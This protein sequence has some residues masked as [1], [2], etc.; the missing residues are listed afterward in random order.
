MSTFHFI[1]GPYLLL[2]IAAAVLHILLAVFSPDP[3]GYVWDF[4]SDA[5]IWV[6]QNKELPMVDSCWVCYHPPLLPVIGAAIFSLV[7]FFTDSIDIKLFVVTCLLNLVSLIFCIYA[8]AIYLKFRKH[9]KLDLVLW[10]FLL[11]VPVRFIASFSI[12]ADVLVSTFIVI[13]LYYFVLFT[14]EN[15]QRTL[16]LSAVFIGLA[17]LT[18][19]TGVVIAA[20]YGGILLFRFLKNIG[21]ENFLNGLKFFLITFVIGGF[22]YVNNIIN[23]GT[24]IKGNRAWDNPGYYMYSYKEF[25]IPK[26]IQTFEDDRP[27]KLKHYPQYNSEV[28]NSLYGQIWTDMSFFTIAYR[29]GQ[30]ETKHIYQGKFMPK[31]LLWAILITGLVPLV[32]GVV[33]FG[34]LM[35]QKNSYVLTVM[36]FVSIAVY[37]HWFMGHNAWMLKT[38]YL[39]YL[40]P[41]CLIAINNAGY[42][43]KPVILEKLLL[44]SVFLSFLYCFFFAVF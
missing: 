1:K 35:F 33:G 30:H 12:E 3:N 43:I 44:P 2:L 13:S 21:S 16:Y 27:I 15:D 25:S 32:S 11:F 10:A 7:D 19:Y 28:L 26:I 18:K 9:E 34:I 24:P 14:Q 41:I 40:L 22:P 31:L 38:K 36:F 5:I 4:Y 17:S 29:H 37:V 20:V 42:L 23:Y 8:F 39:L 6:Y